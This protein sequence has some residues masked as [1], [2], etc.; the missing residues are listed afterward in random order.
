MSTGM[1]G[2][3]ALVVVTALSAWL[4]LSV[5]VGIAVGACLRPRTRVVGEPGRRES[6]IRQ[7][8]RAA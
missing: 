7:P 6:G 1:V 4:L 5:L 3:T 2:N 8:V